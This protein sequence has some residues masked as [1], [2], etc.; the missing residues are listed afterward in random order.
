MSNNNRQRRKIA[1]ISATS[2][3]PSPP[4]RKKPSRITEHVYV[5][6]TQ[7]GEFV[8]YSARSFNKGESTFLLPIIRVL[9]EQPDVR[10]KLGINAI[11]S[12]VDQRTFRE[13]LTFCTKKGG[14]YEWKSFVRILS[15]PEENST[16]QKRRQYGT[17]M[18][19]WLTTC[20][21]SD[22]YSFE[23]VF[24]FM[25]DLTPT[26]PRHLGEIICKDDT[27][28]IITA[29]FADDHLTE[30]DIFADDTKLLDYFGARVTSL[31]RAPAEPNPTIAPYLG[32]VVPPDENQGPDFDTFFAQ[33]QNIDEEPGDASSQEAEP[34]EKPNA[35]PVVGANIHCGPS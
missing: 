1:E 27:V 17:L 34:K 10:K 13:P 3:S 25:A 5:E 11:C 4:R 24:K 31:L 22:L 12:R 21:Q 18:A 32:Q 29:S 7:T 9:E 6:A 28:R 26:V 33:H 16:P 15:C 2:P 35:A 19:D 30:Q 20:G 8:V 14:P 23:A